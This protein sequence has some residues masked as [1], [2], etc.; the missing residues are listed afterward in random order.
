MS[1]STTNGIFIRDEASTLVDNDMHQYAS[2][3]AFT[4][5]VTFSINKVNFWM[6]G[7]IKTKRLN[8]DSFAN[9][10]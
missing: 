7:F 6:F 4:L 8:I 3:D 5:Q 9:E 1:K 10:S 2:V